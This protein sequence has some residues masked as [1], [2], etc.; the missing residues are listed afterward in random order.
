MPIAER[1][2]RYRIR[3]KWTAS[4]SIDEVFDAESKEEAE[5]IAEYFAHGANP[6]ADEIAIDFHTVEEIE[7]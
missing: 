1:E 2:R 3:A 4:G 5:D 7:Q 6:Y